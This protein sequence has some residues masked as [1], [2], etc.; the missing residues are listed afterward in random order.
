L[1]E[2]VWEAIINCDPTYDGKFYYGVVTTGIFCRPSCR[3]KNPKRENVRVFWSINDAI[4]A[5]FRPCK[6]CRPDHLRWPDE[7]LAHLVLERIENQYQEPITL[8]T[9]AHMFHISPYHLHRTFKRIVGTTPAEYLRTVR[10]KAA[11]RMLEETDKSIAEI[12]IT[13][14]FPNAAHFST[15]FQRHYGMVP[16]AYRNQCGVCR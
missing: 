16:S 12:A 9:L 4:S 10:M 7:D 5:N 14:G 1:N 15:V 6:R 2:E 3:S 13:V 8:A 11:K